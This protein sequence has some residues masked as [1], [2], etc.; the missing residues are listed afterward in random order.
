MKRSLLLALLLFVSQFCH[1]AKQINSPDGAWSI[2]ETVQGTEHG[3]GIFSKASAEPVS[4]IAHDLVGL[5]GVVVKWSDD[6][7][8]VAIAERLRHCPAIL[9]AWLDGTGWH[10][11]E[12]FNCPP[13]LYQAETGELGKWVASDTIEVHGTLD[14]GLSYTYKMQMVPGSYIPGA[15]DFEEDAIEVFEIRVALIHKD[16][17]GQIAK[18]EPTRES[19]KS[20]Q[21]LLSTAPVTSPDGAWVV[22]PGAGDDY[23]GL[24]FFSMPG[25]HRFGA[26]V[27]NTG[28]M[29]GAS[30][31]WAGDS[32]KVIALGDYEGGSEIYVGWFDGKEWNVTTEPEGDFVPLAVLAE[33][34]QARGDLKIEKTAL[35]DWVS[36]DTIAICGVMSV[37]GVEF[38]YGYK[39]QIV[40]GTYQYRAWLRL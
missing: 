37:G 2:Q 10:K 39:I 24:M 30:V 16:Q 14:N 25:N 4:I 12:L 11:A 3:I 7:K 38:K 26:L 31:K 19:Q 17:A 36:P 5:P 23:P 1:A 15:N 6:S 35:G 8:H 29:K 27:L 13:L 18:A 21:E 22:R 9:A 33:K 32:K 28:G 34:S 20:G 40:P